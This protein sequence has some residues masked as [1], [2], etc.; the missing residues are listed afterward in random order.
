M[1]N[2]TSP[3]PL[4]RVVG[5]H[6]RLRWEKAERTDCDWLCHYELVIPFDE[7]D[8]RREVYDKDGEL[9]AE[10]FCNVVSMGSP[11]KLTSTKAP[12]CYDDWYAPFRDGAH[13]MWDAA[14]L[15]N[16]PVYVIAPDGRAFLRPNPKAD[17]AAVVGGSASS[18]LLA[19]HPLPENKP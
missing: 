5:P 4:H 14:K 18:E 11:T 7:H 12:C 10:R 1:E 13:A 17:P 9:I 16:L 15:G 19:N 6:L 2:K 3:A 8:I